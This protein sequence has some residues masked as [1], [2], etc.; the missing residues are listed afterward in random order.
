MSMGGGSSTE[1]NTEP[2]EGQ[3]P[4]LEGIYADAADLYQNS[5]MVPWQGPTLAPVN[6]LQMQGIDMATNNAY[7]I[8][9]ASWGFIGGANSILDWGL[10]KASSGGSGPTDYSSIL[11]PSAVGQSSAPTWSPGTYTPTAFSDLVGQFSPSE[12]DGPAPSYSPS[13]YTVGEYTPGTETEFYLNPTDNPAFMP[14]LEAAL[15]PVYDRFINEIFPAISSQAELQGAYGGSRQGVMTALSSQLLNR[16]V[17]DATAKAV[18]DAYFKERALLAE[19]ENL[20]EQL[21]TQRYLGL[22]DLAT[23]RYTTTEG[24]LQASDEAA[25]QLASDRWKLSESLASDRWTTEQTLQNQRY[26]GLEELATSRFNTQESL[27]Q[28][29]AEAL[30]QLEAQKWIAGL[31]ANT[32]IYNTQLTNEGA[33]ERALLGLTPDLARIGMTGVQVAPSI[34]TAAGDQLRTY[35]QQFL[36]EAIGQYNADMMAPWNNLQNYANIIMGSSPGSST[37]TTTSTNAGMESFIG[38]ALIAGALAFSSKELK[39][40]MGQIGPVLGKL[41]DVPVYRWRYKGSGR[42]H[43]G[44]YA[45]DFQDAAGVGDGVTIQLV[46]AL[47]FLLKASQELLDRVETLEARLKEMDN[48]ARS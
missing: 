36:D 11:A 3:K 21:A 19:R 30:A 20:E 38:P 7:G 25:A 13:A 22:E 47:G 18:S 14:G 48:A 43:I 17:A 37:T 8:N 35:D 15:N 40:S 2:W 34:L 45:E 41:R 32:S 46:D 39:E 6:D 26:L 44:P 12:Y 24:L 28:R 31:N 42:D 10:G 27:G 23:R 16:E 4:Y 9:D 33:F 29:N 5:P 1:S